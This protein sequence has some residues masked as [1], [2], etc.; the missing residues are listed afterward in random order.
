MQ[1]DTGDKTRKKSLSQRGL[2]LQMMDQKHT[3]GNRRKNIVFQSILMTPKEHFYTNE[4]GKSSQPASF[5]L[6][7]LMAKYWHGKIL[8]RQHEPAVGLKVKKVSKEIKEERSV[9][10]EG[11]QHQSNN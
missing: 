5:C 8:N 1:T 9:T 4:K 2:K 6:P 7:F 3:C 11:T 10:D